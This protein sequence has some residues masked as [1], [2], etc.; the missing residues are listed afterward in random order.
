PEPFARSLGS[1]RASPSRIFHDGGRGIRSVFPATV[2]SGDL[3]KS[4][5]SSGSL[6]E[7][8]SGPLAQ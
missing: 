6:V 7:C 5:A 2:A 4:P 8:S 1:H 3:G